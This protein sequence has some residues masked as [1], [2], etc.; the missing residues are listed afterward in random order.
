MRRTWTILLGVI[1]L[2]SALLINPAV[3][4]RLGDE[5]M[6]RWEPLPPPPD[7]PDRAELQR[8]LER[9]LLNEPPP[10]P[11]PDSG[12]ATAATV[13]G[14]DDREPIVDES[15]I[16]SSFLRWVVQL[17]LFYDEDLQQDG[18]CTGFLL[19]WNV[20]LTA[21]HCVYDRA[22][23]MF[24]R[25]VI[26]APGSTTDSQ[27]SPRFPYG[28]GGATSF[29]IRI[30]TGYVSAYGD[31]R[32]R[33]DFAVVRLS[34]TDW[35][36]TSLGPFPDASSPMVQPPSSILFD[37]QHAVIASGYP[38]TG[39]WYY[40]FL[41]C[42]MY[43]EAKYADSVVYP[44]PI[45]SRPVFST[46]LDV[47]GGQS[48]SAVLMLPVDESSPWPYTS[49]FIVL[50][51]LTGGSAIENIGT[52]LEASVIQALAS[53]CA[54]LGCTF[55][56]T[57]SGP[58]VATPTSTP[59][60]TAT[61]TPTP[62]PSPTPSPTPTVSPTPPGGGPGGPPATFF[63]RTNGVPP[64]SAVIAFVV[65]PAFVLTNCGTA[66]VAQEGSNAVFV[67][68][69]LDERQRPGCGAPGRTVRFYLVPPGEPGRF[70]TESGTWD[71]PGPIE[72][73]LTAGAPFNREA[74]APG[75]TRN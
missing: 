17:F 74:S 3:H 61:P 10:Q 60:P 57:L 24:A 32:Y 49:P 70:A 22:T 27:G 58:G 18:H 53:Y 33:Y 15:T 56:Y 72:L 14:F 63:G 46:S 21:A 41:W 11:I 1:S 7:T 55:A 48:G 65:G 38:G 16:R 71:G 5:P 8:Q 12:D 64:G 35:S 26:A 39:C 75:L 45:L 31:Q 9:L 67:I 54:S 37:R 29:D 36:S 4:A 25:V 69:V 51:I 43:A 50:G 44:H 2:L 34:D 42:R 47:E 52:M 19:N 68:D 66:T 23:G 20:V 59:T 13:F 30:P 40:Q 62:T 28:L 73:D 6:D